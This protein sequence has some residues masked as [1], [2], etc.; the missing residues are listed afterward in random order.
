MVSCNI[1]P[2]INIK[3]EFN[4]GSFTIDAK[5][6]DILEISFLG[7]KTQQIT[8]AAETNLKIILPAAILTLDDVVLT[9]Y[10]SQKVKEITGSVAIVKPKDLISV[11]AGQVEQMLQGRV[12]GLNII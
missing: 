6:G 9:G 11:P 10:T 5:A 1:F 8:I 3:I 12:A 4:D 2:R 7:F